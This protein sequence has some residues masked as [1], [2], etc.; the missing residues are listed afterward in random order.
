MVKNILLPLGISFFTFQQL[1]FLVSVYKGEEEI[2]RFIDYSLFV[3]FFPQLVA[4]PIVL[5]SEMI[6]QFQDPER[7]YFHSENFAAGL[8]MGDGA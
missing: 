2:G 5:Y 3:S 1:S 6:P 7:R 4:G 8:Y